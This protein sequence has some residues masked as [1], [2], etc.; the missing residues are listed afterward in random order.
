M[1]QRPL[2]VPEIVAVVSLVA[3]FVATWL[4][5]FG[6]SAG[7]GAPGPLPELDLGTANGWD[8][9]LLWSFVPLLLGAGLVTLLVLPV[10]GT[11][12]ERDALPPVLPLV[13]GGGAAGL[14]VVKLLIGTGV[15]GAEAAAA[16]GIDIDV[17]REVGL[18]LAVL[19]SLGMLAAGVLA[20]R[21]DAAGP[22]AHGTTPAPPR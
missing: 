22:P 14:V 10:L 8:T 9:G 18:F 4:P 1:E 16:F 12:I 17:Q 5:W 19:A 2:G 13:L 6:V 15:R 11:S 20:F 21:R 7:N 3:F